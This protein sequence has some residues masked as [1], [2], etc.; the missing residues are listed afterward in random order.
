MIRNITISLFIILALF[1]GGFSVNAQ[2]AEELRAKISDYNAK[3]QQLDAEIRRYEQDLLKV[4]AEKQ[5]LQK[6]IDELNISRNKLS[7]DIK[8]TENQIA[9][10][11]LTI[12]ELSNEIDQKEENIEDNRKAIAGTLREIAKRNDD[13]LIE[14]L[15]KYNN[16]AE[17]W[18]QISELHGLRD[19]I[20]EAIVELEELKSILENKVGES[21]E[22]KSELL[23]FKENLANQKQAVDANKEEKD[24]L[25]A[26]TKSQEKGYQDLLSQKRAAREQFER[27]LADFESQLQFVLDPNS[28]P[29]KGSGVLN[30]PFSTTSYSPLSIITQY[31]GKTSDSGRLYA[32]G[33]HNGVD[34]GIPTGSKILSAASGV[35]R[36]SG[37]TDVGSCLSYGK[38]VL[39]DH[40]N[41]LSTLYAHLSSISVKSGQTVNSGSI[42]GYSG[43]TGYSTGP[44]LHFTVFAREGVNVR[45]LGDYKSGSSPCVLNGVRIPVAAANVYFDPMAYLPN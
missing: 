13:S 43:N 17:F 14:T 5:T 45:N 15:M 22:Q 2:G 20:R 19:K 32:S 29:S 39:V 7:T 12:A 42:L 33:T 10:T 31:F 26:Q 8:K 9:K 35:V 23:G 6:A 4:G 27:E 11:N 34:F 44:H 28:V 3:I 18:G 1:I 38:W 36:E 25:L 37:N 41:G 40:E 24:S 30:W 16:L 21:R